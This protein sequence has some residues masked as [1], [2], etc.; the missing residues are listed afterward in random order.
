MFKLPSQQHNFCNFSHDKQH[1]LNL[2]NFVQY[3]S[4]GNL[5]SGNEVKIVGSGVVSINT[6]A[7]PRTPHIGD[8]MI[9]SFY[10]KFSYSTF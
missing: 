9:V 3:T 8:G 7:I 5:L 2:A 4:S 6:V 10:L 1:I